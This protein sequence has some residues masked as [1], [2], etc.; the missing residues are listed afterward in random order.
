VSECPHENF[1]AD[2]A[3]GR[4]TDDGGRVHSFLAEV[5]VRCLDCGEPFHFLGLEAGLSFTRPTVDV[6]ATTLHAPIA[7]GVAPL[8]ARMRSEVPGR[9]EDAS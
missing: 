3:V 1:A 6:A 8:P 5:T 2:V 9:P 4:I 7:P